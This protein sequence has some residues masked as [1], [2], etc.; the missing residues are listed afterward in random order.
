MVHTDVY[1]FLFDIPHDLVLLLVDPSV[2][3]Y[4][5]STYNTSTVRVVWCYAVSITLK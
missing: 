3:N 4:C 2:L 1:T 5:N